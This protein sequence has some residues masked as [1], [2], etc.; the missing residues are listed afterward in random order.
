MRLVIGNKNY[1]SW[2]LRAWLY[3]GESGIPFEEVRIPLYCADSA[4]RIA[5]FSPAGRVPVLIDDDGT[6]VWDSLA[7]VEHARERHSGVDWPRAHAARAR[8]RSIVAEMHS[9]FLALR[10]ELPF[11]ARARSPVEPDRLSDRARQQ[12]ERVLSIW[13]GCRRE[14]AGDGDWLFGR[15]SIADAF[16]APVALR[17]VTY[18][19]AA[20]PAAQSFVDA[21]T[22]LASIREWVAAAAQEVESLDFIDTRHP[23]GPTPLSFG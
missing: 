5:R 13:D 15:F 12:V 8:A 23:A 10:E 18:S 3:L 20:P 11:N 16:Y 19:I 2:S 4:A 1:S 9:G 22:R 7:I 14:H 6:T 17:F 21:V